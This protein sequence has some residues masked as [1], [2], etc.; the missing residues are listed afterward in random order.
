MCYVSCMSFL[1]I[2]KGEVYVSQIKCVNPFT[3]FRS[4][5]EQDNLAVAAT[6]MYEATKEQG[7][8]NDAKGW[9]QGGVSWALSWDDSKVA[10][11]VSVHHNPLSHSQ[12]V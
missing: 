3:V 4:T 12:C 6:F 1:M 11:D 9:H 5:S 7:Y 10:A 8:L 2:N